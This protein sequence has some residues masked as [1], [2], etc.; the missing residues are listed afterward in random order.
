MEQYS[1]A[2]DYYRSKSFSLRDE[3][4][5]VADEAYT[6]RIQ[7]IK[8]LALDSKIEHLL[9]HP[10]RVI[11]NEAF[12]LR[13]HF[14]L[15]E[16]H[17]TQKSWWK[18]S[19]PDRMPTDQEIEL[20]IRSYDMNIKRGFIIGVFSVQEHTLREY[21]RK[22]DP[23]ILNNAK[24]SFWKIRDHFFDNYVFNNHQKYISALKLIASIRNSFHNDGLFYPYDDNDLEIK[25]R[26]DTFLFEVG[27]PVSFAE[28]K[29]LTDITEEI[30]NFFF[31]LNSNANFYN[32]ITT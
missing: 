13:L 17:L 24:A 9:L 25:Y 15:L 2:F 28:W 7:L 10:F 22:T 4:E 21:I 27:K 30:A 31:E 6:T 16:A 29:L 26:G 11:R 20:H 12:A 5:R 19:H 18:I 14:A 3:I 32:Q 1:S 23:N 8:D